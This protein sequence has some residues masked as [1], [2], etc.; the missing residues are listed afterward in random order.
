MTPIAVS[1][2]AS[3]DSPRNDLRGYRQSS[4]TRMPEATRDGLTGFRDD[5]PAIE[6]REAAVPV[7]WMVDNPNGTKEIYEKV[8]AELGWTRLRAASSTAPGRARRAAG[9]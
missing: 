4:A 8:R 2:A 5:A 6:W 9:A 7:A 3:R 1:S